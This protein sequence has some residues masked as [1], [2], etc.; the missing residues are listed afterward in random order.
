[1]CR[2]DRLR[3]KNVQDTWHVGK[4]L[5]MTRAKSNTSWATSQSILT[6]TCVDLPFPFGEYKPK[7][8]HHYI[9]VVSNSSSLGSVTASA[10]L[11]GGQLSLS[12]CLVGL[13][14][15]QIASCILLKK[16]NQ[17]TYRWYNV[18][19][20]NRTFAYFLRN[21]TFD[22]EKHFP[23]G[24]EKKGLFGS[25][26][27]SLLKFS[28]SS[29]RNLHSEPR[30]FRFARKARNGEKATPESASFLSFCGQI[31]TFGLWAW[32]ELKRNPH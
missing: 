27:P 25:S 1:M 26:A 14:R 29:S 3:L 23:D 2:S 5:I 24:A 11:D 18:I 8:F 10:Q 21:C 15:V 31:E 13:C 20:A 6:E 16:Q 4:Q 32:R 22:P 19:K 9:P 12:D 28:D 7:S 30:F 17:H